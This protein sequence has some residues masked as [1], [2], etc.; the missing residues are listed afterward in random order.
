MPLVHLGLPISKI[1]SPISTIISANPKDIQP[2][3]L[4]LISIL[5]TLDQTSYTCEQFP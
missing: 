4:L 5:I 3:S 1:F 2:S